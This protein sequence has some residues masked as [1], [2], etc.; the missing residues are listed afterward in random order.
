MKSGKTLRG[1]TNRPPMPFPQRVTF[2][3]TVFNPR[4][5][6]GLERNIKW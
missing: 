4:A 6:V 1:P 5:L 3:L 2:F